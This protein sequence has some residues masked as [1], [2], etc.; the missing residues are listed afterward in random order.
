[1][2]AEKDLCVLLNNIDTGYVLLL[3]SLKIKVIYKI[4]KKTMYIFL[5]LILFYRA[6]YP[7]AT[8]SITFQNKHSLIL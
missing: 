8:R 3:T 6:Y 4:K 5:N 1:M 7:R 2:A